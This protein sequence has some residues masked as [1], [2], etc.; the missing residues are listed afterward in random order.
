MI[1]LSPCSAC[2]HL[3]QSRPMRRNKPFTTAPV[4]CQTA[5]NHSSSGSPDRSFKGNAGKQKQ[6][7]AQGIVGSTAHSTTFCFSNA[8]RAAKASLYQQISVGPGDIPCKLLQQQPLQLLFPA[9]QPEQ[10]K[11]FRYQLCI[12]LQVCQ[13]TIQLTHRY[14]IMC[15]CGTVQDIELSHFSL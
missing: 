5:V 6:Q 7:H 10:T 12:T 2:I 8:Q 3:H 9:L 11:M 1:S 13:G 4:C 15:C 14:L